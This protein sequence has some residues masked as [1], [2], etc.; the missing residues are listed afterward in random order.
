M[1]YV[2]LGLI[3]FLMFVWDFILFVH[4]KKVAE[5]LDKI[6]RELHKQRQNE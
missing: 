5:R 3:L 4:H 1:T 6:I 2:L